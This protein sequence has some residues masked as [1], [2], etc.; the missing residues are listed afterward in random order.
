MPK[1][2]L[3]EDDLDL[4][5]SLRD[6]F[7]KEQHITDTVVNGADAL[8]RLRDLQYDVIILDINLPGEIDGFEVLRRY[9]A[10]AG[11]CPVILLTSRGEMHDKLAGLDF[12]A[13]DYLTKPFEPK[14]LSARVRAQLRRQSTA[15]RDAL[16]AGELT[17]EIGKFR[18]KK[19]DQEIHLQPREFAVLEFLMRHPDEVFSLD[20]LLHRIWPVDSEASPE[21]LRV[22]IT[23][24]R[25]KIDTPEKPSYIQ[26]VHRVGYKF[27]VP[28]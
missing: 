27:Q 23:N 12:G 2:L 7:K 17:L 6:W 14:E 5:E 15:Y 11:V 9:R 1:I 21:S 4:A 28:D 19:G 18:L 16:R 22:H 10:D 24:I 8:E 20:A 13:E 3:V 25:S 26:T